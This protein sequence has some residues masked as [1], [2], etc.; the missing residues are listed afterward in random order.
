MTAIW[1]FL[2]AIPI[3]VWVA[4]ALLGAGLWYGSSRYDAGQA[5]KQA[6]WDKSVERGKAEVA[7][8]TAEAGKV[9]TVVETK[10]VEKIV[11]IEGKAREIQTV[12]EVFV[13]VDSGS[14]P[15][16]FRLFYDGAITNTI[17]DPASIAN[18]APIPIAD[19]ADTHARNAELCHIA[20]ATVEG[21]QDWAIQQAKVK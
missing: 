13:P 6:D 3:W 1:L 17:P 14:L 12:R 10:V 5:D 20:Y 19:V 18:A 16:A 9:T 7:R 8:L 2:K 21:W 15:G 11:R 4:L